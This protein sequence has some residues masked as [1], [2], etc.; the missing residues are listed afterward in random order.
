MTRYV[1][2]G[3]G[4]I[5]GGIDGRLAQAGQDAVLVARGA[6]LAA[7]KESGL[8]LRS[9]KSDVRVP[10]T[11]IAGP[12]E[13]ELS[14]D[15]VLVVATKTQQAPEVLPAWGRRART[16]GRAHGGHR[17]RPAARPDGA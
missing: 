12:D 11:A 2:I 15:D 3:A 13:L 8:R 5:G 17:G 4:A 7:L 9:P 14:D 1:I 16:C 6:H 10:V